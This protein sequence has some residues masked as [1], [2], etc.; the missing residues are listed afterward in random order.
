MLRAILCIIIVLLFLLLM[1]P[2]L[3]VEWIVGK[4]SPEAKEKS[5]LRIVQAALRLIRLAAGTK[6]TVIGGEN[7]PTDKPVLY[8][9]N[10]RSYFDIVLTYPRC[11]NRTGYVAKK[12]MEKI[13]LL[14]VWMRYLHCLFLD[15]KDLK[16]GVKTILAAVQKVKDG[17]SIFIYPEG[18]RNRAADETELLPFHDGSF[19]IASRAGCPVVPVAISNSASIF[20]AHMPFVKA[21]H[22]VIE[23]GKPFYISDLDKDTQKHIGAYTQ[24][25]IRQMLI[26]NKELI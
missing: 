4:F 13:P 17:I 22:V 19:K 16:Q 26:K 10:H 8:V 6:V 12:E 20:E 24:E 1:I 5:S 23:Y 3:L 14:S 11:R 21:A 7:V 2:V 9:G 15:R 18:T 25:I